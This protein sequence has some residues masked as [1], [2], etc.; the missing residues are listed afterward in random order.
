MKYLRA[1]AD[2]FMPTF[3]TTLGLFGGIASGVG[4]VF[5]ILRITGLLTW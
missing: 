3:G 4:I 2:N 1:F 5:T